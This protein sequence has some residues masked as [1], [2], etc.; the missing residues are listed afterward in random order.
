MERNS[1]NPC[2]PLSNVVSIL[3]GFY[4]PNTPLNSTDIRQAAMYCIPSTK[5]SI[6]RLVGKA[7]EV[8]TATRLNFLIRMWIY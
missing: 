4:S 8:R 5:C 1:S 7:C 3:P 2:F 6:G